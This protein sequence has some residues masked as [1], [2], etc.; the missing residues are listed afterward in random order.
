MIT[1][2]LV[3]LYL[4]IAWITGYG[5]LAVKELNALERQ[6]Y[7]S[8]SKASERIKIILMALLWLPMIPAWLI[9]LLFVSLYDTFKWIIKG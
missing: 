9:H 7:I 1:A 6:P 5:I 8:P 2:L 3:L 4:L